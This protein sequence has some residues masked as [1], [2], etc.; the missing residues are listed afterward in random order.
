MLN[1]APYDRV[2]AGPDG[3]V[4]VCAPAKL[5]LFLHVT[6][7]R[8]DGYHEIE[9]LFV[10]TKA[11]DTVTLRPAE[12]LSFAVDGVF[13]ADMAETSLEDNLVVRAARA[14]AE[15]AGVDCNVR[16]DLT[17][18]LPVASGL[19]GG[20]ADAAA[21]LLGLQALWQLDLP[22]GKLEALALSLGADVPACLS[23]KPQLVRGI[24]EKLSPVDLTWSAGVVV[25][26]P[27]KQ[28]STREVFEG[29][30]RFRQSRGLPPY[31]V[32]LSDMRAITNDISTLDILT[33]NSLQD[34][35]GQ[36]CSEVMEIERFLRLN[37]DH[38]LV[39]MSGSGASVIALYHDRRAAE[40]VAR[41]VRDHNPA[42]WVMADEIG[43]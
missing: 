14:L 28:L 12:T 41:R 11:G 34:P 7:R 4:R 13:A 25:V 20:S 17:K 15:A 9:S 36:L 43:A 22:A 23:S 31:D 16:I 30:H 39:R 18:D 24:G 2:E 3:C 8:A 27:L 32:R 5:N 40:A 19:G 29:L 6:G 1:G 42:W 26:N 38:E 33:R 35:A 10:F 37:S 21:T